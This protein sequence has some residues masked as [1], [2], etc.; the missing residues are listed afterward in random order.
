MPK[1]YKNQN[2][3]KKELGG[4]VDQY[5]RKKNIVTQKLRT[6]VNF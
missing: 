1:I 5:V 6:L 4:I 3:I 2:A